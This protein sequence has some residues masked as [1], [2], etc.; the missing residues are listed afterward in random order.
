MK[1]ISDCMYLRHHR[2]GRRGRQGAGGGPV[3]VGRQLGLR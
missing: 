2:R 3:R 1:C